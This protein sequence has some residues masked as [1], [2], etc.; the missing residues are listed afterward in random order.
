MKRNAIITGIA[1]LAGVLYCSWPLGYILNPSVAKHSLAS[2]L[3][4]PH[5][6]YNWLFIGLD[7]LSS[8]LLL[9]VIAVLSKQKQRKRRRSAL[10][11]ICMWM[12]V[13]FAAGTIADALYPENCI[14]GVQTCASFTHNSSLL[15]HG[16]FSIVAS[17][18][19]FGS[20]CIAWLRRRQNPIFTMVL[21]C[22]IIFGAVSL[23]EAITPYSTGNWSQHYYIALCSVWMAFV[24]YAVSQLER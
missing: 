21:V 18:A 5:Q 24:P 19:L 2:G 15:L 17:L 16:S 12:V 3:E 6:P 10:L 20:L 14:P 23:L 11:P 8:L 9:G 4:A 7:V 22:Y 13:I 1:T